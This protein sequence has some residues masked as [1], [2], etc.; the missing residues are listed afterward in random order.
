MKYSLTQQ[1][2]KLTEQEWQLL[3]RLKAY[4]TVFTLNEVSMNE[5]PIA[6]GRFELY[7]QFFSLQF[8]GYLR[9]VPEFKDSFTITQYAHGY[10]SQHT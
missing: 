7:K 9:S 4:K 10:I 5:S 6:I 8:Q 1:S 2:S 3:L